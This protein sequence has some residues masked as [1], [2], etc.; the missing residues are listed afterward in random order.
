MPIL[1]DHDEFGYPI[2]GGWSYNS[3]MLSRARAKSSEHHQKIRQKKV[4]FRDFIKNLP[5][6]AKL[7]WKQEENKT[8]EGICVPFAPNPMNFSH[9]HQQLRTKPIRT[10]QMLIKKRE[11]ATRR[12]K[13]PH[14]QNSSH[15]RIENRRS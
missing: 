9:G 8:I 10:A 12:S 15:D 14:D 7:V 3:S 4:L 6:G 5:L 11:I 13:P 1:E 2:H